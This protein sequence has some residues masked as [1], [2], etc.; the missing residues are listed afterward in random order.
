[1]LK[2]NFSRIYSEVL[3]MQALHGP[4]RNSRQQQQLQQQLA[5]HRLR[6]P[7]GRQVENLVCSSS[8]AARRINKFERSNNIEPKRAIAGQGHAANNPALRMALSQHL[9]PAALQPGGQLPNQQLS[10]GELMQ[11]MHMTPAASTSLVNNSNTTSKLSVSGAP[12]H[13]TSTTA[14]AQST[15]NLSQ[16][17]PLGT[18]PNLFNGPLGI[19]PHQMFA[20]NPE[21][22]NSLQQALSA[23]HAVDPSLLNL[24]TPFAGI[25]AQNPMAASALS[26]F[27]GLTHPDAQL[28]SS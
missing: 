26:M 13:T 17:N 18:T 10:A 11:A 9:L 27:G 2:F 20:S 16:N 19:N 28:V 21:F 1:M 24:S 4:H 5:A 6:Y 22:A 23:M 8:V 3:A 15:T 12:P 25:R 7:L 14:S